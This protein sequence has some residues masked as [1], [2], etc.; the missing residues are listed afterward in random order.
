VSVICVP[1][2]AKGE[3]RILYGDKE[4]DF[5]YISAHESTIAAMTVSYDGNVLAT[6]SEKGTIVRLFDTRTGS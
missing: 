3:V 4:E 5:K 6:A 1:G 2:T